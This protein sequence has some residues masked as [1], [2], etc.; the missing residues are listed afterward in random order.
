MRGEAGENWEREALRAAI[1]RRNSGLRRFAAWA[2]TQRCDLGPADA[3]A[4]VAALFELLPAD[5][6]E[7]EVDASGVRAMHRLLAAAPSR[8]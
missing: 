4:S 8:G 5:S 6:R 7:R 2:E 1:E 3:I